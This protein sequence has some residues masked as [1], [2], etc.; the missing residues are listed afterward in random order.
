[1]SSTPLAIA[2]DFQ[3]PATSK[4]ILINSN[5]NSNYFYQYCPF[6]FTIATRLAAT[7]GHPAPEGFGFTGSCQACPF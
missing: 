5:F 4:F 1:M 3:P 7:L 6:L 2:S